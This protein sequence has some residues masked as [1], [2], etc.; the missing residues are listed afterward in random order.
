MKWEYKVLK[1]EATG[2][3]GGKVDAEAFEGYMNNLGRN[4]WE[5]VTAFDTNQSYGQTRDVVAVFKRQR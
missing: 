5:L 4:G 2:F 3:F 1:L